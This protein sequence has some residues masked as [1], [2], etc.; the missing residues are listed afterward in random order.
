MY[1][2]TRVQCMHDVS[3]IRV[4]LGAPYTENSRAKNSSFFAKS[5]ASI[6]L[7][8]TKTRVLSKNSSFQVAKVDNLTFLPRRVEVFQSRKK[9]SDL[10][11]RVFTNS[12][13]FPRRVGLNIINPRSIQKNKSPTFEIFFGCCME[14]NVTPKM[15]PFC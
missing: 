10:K 1:I 3:F 12:T 6:T 15:S 8:G 9:K 7:H 11:S 5:R 4:T 13:F 2:K 14:K